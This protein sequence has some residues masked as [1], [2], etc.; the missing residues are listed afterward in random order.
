[1]ECFSTEGLKRD[2]L[3][4]KVSLTTGECASMGGEKKGLHV[5]T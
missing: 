3:Y 4:I 5:K 2:D 1:M